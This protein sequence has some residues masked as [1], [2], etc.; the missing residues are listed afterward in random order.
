MGDSSVRTEFGHERSGQV[1]V[2][3][4]RFGRGLCPTASAPWTN[5]CSARRLAFFPG[6]F[7]CLN[8]LNLWLCRLIC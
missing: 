5:A 2:E 1:Q 3:G 7:I 6:K 4:P 8:D